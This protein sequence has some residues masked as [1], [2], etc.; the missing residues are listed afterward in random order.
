M[1]L[2]VAAV[3]Q[4]RQAA[5]ELA[6]ADDYRKRA[7]ALGAKLGFSKLDFVTVATSRAAAAPTRMA[8]EAKRLIARIPPGAHCIALDEKGRSLAS[9]AFARH[10]GTLRDRGVRDLV[11]LIGGPDGLSPSLLGN[12]A[13][14]LALGPQTWPHQLVH[15]MLA[16]QIYRAFTILS[17]H[18]YHRG[19]TE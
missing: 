4:S 5:P 7:A 10:L 14:S 3:G 15:V 16:E 1:R 17:G 6:L 9:E 18:P 12:A 19:R 13:E 2:T 11:F 8:E